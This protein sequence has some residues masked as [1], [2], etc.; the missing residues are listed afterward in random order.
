MRRPLATVAVAA[1][2]ASM[3]LLL[4]GSG[5]VRPAYGLSYEKLNKIQRRIL[6]GFATSELNPAAT[7]AA[8]RP[9]SARQASPGDTYVP[10]D[11]LGCP[12]RKGSN[13]KANRNCL[14]LADLDLAGRSQANNETS[15]AIDLATG[16]LV[17]GDN[18]YRR[19][20]SGCV[21]AYSRDGGRTWS[22]SE[23]PTG[24]T[25]GDAFGAAREYWQGAG[26]PAVATDT[27]GNTYFACLQFNRGQPTTP[28]A[29]ASSAIYLY[30][31]TGNAGA[32]WNFPGRPVV[33][34]ADLAGTSGVL[35]DKELLAV[36]NHRRSPFRDRVYVTWTEFAA[37]GTAY[38]WSRAS[39]DYGESFG[40][41]VLV[42]GA[43]P[44]CTNTF[45]L[46]TPNGPCNENQFSQPF[47][48][49]DGDL[50]VAWANYNSAA[51]PPGPEEDQPAVG[52]RAAQ[53]PEQPGEEEGENAYQ[54]LL[55]RSTDG[56]AS[57]G[58][59]VK[60]SDFY[61]LPDCETYQDG[62]GA[63]SSCVPEKGATANSF[64][65]ATNYPAGVVDPTDPDRVVVTFGSY[66]NRHSNDDNGCEPAGF[67][68]DTGNPLYTGVKTVGA[69]NNDIV[70]SVSDDGGASFT[71]TDTD[72]RELPSATSAA[73]QR[74][75]DQWFQWA[76]YTRDGK[77]ATSY[78]DRQYGDDELTG[79]SDFSLSGSSS[80]ERFGV[81]RVT[82]SSMP[83][84][85]Q[86]A[87][88]FFGDYTGL[89]AD[90]LA[91]PAWSDTRNPAPV[92]CPGT[93]TPGNPPRLCVTPAPNAPY[94]ND[95]EIYTAAVRVPSG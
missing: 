48:G 22:D 6:S 51:E 55:A 86:F 57:F 37:D 74:T 76:A 30:R 34:T 84:P 4:P 21:A 94:N 58:A 18:D 28:V 46:P 33:E 1:L 36:D 93:G 19:G 47:V 66:I 8:V 69:C 23:V 73:H 85:T 26:D 75:T 71:G 39:A 68:E 62:A 9:R 27:R 17:M 50:Y 20:D 31:S 77:L 14:N 54:I 79:W 87:G 24:F 72:V 91:Y 7:S 12:D 3:V 44:A 42:S 89:A 70:F 88:G 64:F 53:Q 60:V 32:S 78:Y 67:S 15:V 65:R 56:G 90:R 10:T 13:V 95:Q 59:P 45:E 11:S 80:L 2:L 61:D 63:G 81:R 38:I 40:P 52:D 49:P 29:D 25:R 83:P 43:S 41:R 35:Q 16:D 82:S 5:A 92:L